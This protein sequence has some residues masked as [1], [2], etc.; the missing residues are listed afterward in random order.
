MVRRARSRIEERARSA[1]RDASVLARIPLFNSFR[2]LGWPHMRPLT[3][4][5]VV[6]DK[7]NSLCKTCQIGARYLADPSVADGNLTLAEYRSLFASIGQ[8]EWV[9]LS[10]GE[11]FMRKD[12]AEIALALVEET[13][14]R[15]VNVPTNG[16]F[17]H[18]STEAVKKILAGLGDTRLIIN[19]SV[20]AVGALHDEVR[21]FSGNFERLQLVAERLRALR[22]PRL[23]LGCNTVVSSFN[24][25]HVKETVDWV[26]D[27]LRPDSYVIEAAQMRPEYYNEEVSLEGDGQMVKDALEH[28]ME[29]LATAD[30]TG[31]AALVK[32]F[33]IHYYEQSLR[34]LEAQQHRRTLT[35]RCFSAFA[36]CA[37][38]PSGEV[39]SNT[40]R[41]DAMGNVR[42]FDL[43][44]GAL[45]RS[46]TADRVRER[47]RA[48]ACG[49]ETSNVSYPN[50]LLSPGQAA[51]VAWYAL[52]YR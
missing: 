1:L 45:W 15:V 2:E 35:H 11:P 13:R 43:D 50:A 7:C 33:R 28:A 5:F 36:T 10:G 23:T 41:A 47:V 31:V 24:A 3:M 30:R 51:R 22:D 18:A 12:F 39:W 17:V 38:M 49:C 4:S 25:A 29:R 42:D 9:T 20:D 14:P 16:T 34:R 40:Q 27:E 52:R 32:A 19:L 37:V 46:T 48:D 44:F 8:L 21:G 6:T 26:L